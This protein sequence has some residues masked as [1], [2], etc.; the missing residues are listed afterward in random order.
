MEN[1]KTKG[2]DKL[3]NE[4]MGIKGEQQANK[5]KVVKASIC[6]SQKPNDKT[7]N[8]CCK[9][10]FFIMNRDSKSVNKREELGGHCPH[11]R[12]HLLINSK[13]NKE[14]LKASKNNI[15]LDNNCNN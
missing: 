8:L 12:K 11:R 7:C 13:I 10:A 4:N 1:T 3:I 6:K 14:R 5:H 15:N 9:E 2:Q